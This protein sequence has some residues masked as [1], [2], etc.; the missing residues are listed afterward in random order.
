M[1]WLMSVP[2]P[3]E[4]ELKKHW[5]NINRV[6]ETSQTERGIETNEH[7]GL[8][9]FRRCE[10]ITRLTPAPLDTH[11]GEPIRWAVIIGSKEVKSP[12]DDPSSMFIENL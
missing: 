8:L 7:R 1:F 4:I 5:R 6:L 10:A 2:W 11:G 3:E 12:Y 9:L